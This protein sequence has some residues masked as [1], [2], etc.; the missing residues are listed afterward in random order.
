[1]TWRRLA[2]KNLLH[3]ARRYLGYMASSTCAV[4]VF[5]MFSSFT[6]NPHVKQGYMTA[7]ARYVLGGCEYIILF[8][9][10]FFILFFHAALIRMRSREFALFRVLGMTPG[11]V[12]RTVFAESIVTG[13]AAIAAG[14]ALGTV[15]L[16]L[17]LMAMGALLNLPVSIPFALPAQSVLLTVALFG[18]VFVLE[19]FITAARTALHTPKRLMLAERARQ[20]ADKASWWLVAL[21]IAS[22]AIAYDLA[23][24]HSLNIIVNFFPIIG[25][26]ALGTYLLFTQISVKVLGALRRRPLHGVSLLVVARFAHRVRDNALVL[27][28]VTLLSATVLSGM[29]AVFGLKAVVHQNSTQVDPFPVMLVRPQAGAFPLTAN[30]VSRQLAASGTPVAGQVTFSVAAVRAEEAGQAGSQPVHITVVSAS[31]FERVRQHLMDAEPETRSFL[32]DAPPAPGSGR[33]NVFVNYPLVLQKPLFSTNQIRVLDVPEMSFHLNGQYD[34][35][36][37]NEQMGRVSD[38]VLEVSD[39]DYA[40]LTDALPETAKYEITGFDVPD[41]KHALVATSALQNRLNAGQK[42]FLTARADVD[43]EVTQTLATMIF[44]GFFVSVL[45]LLACATVLYFRLQWQMAADKRQFSSL[46]RIGMQDREVHKTLT[47]ELL[48]L[49]FAP[50]AVGLVHSTV[51]MVDFSHLIAVKGNPWPVFVVV[52]GIYIALTAF[53]FAVARIRYAR[54]VLP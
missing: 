44:A 47:R 48:L 24:A 51:A 14:I 38:F 15:F 35:R 23:I 46:L 20:R 43:S 9:A 10:V 28:V 52:A 53:Y 7:R 6:L 30:D 16:K 17:F 41:W 50:V 19:G 49:F 18:A 36:I 40:K 11:Q 34:A 21:G 2:C 33:A 1:M 29:G 13:L 3:N 31:T 4:L 45:F 5:F 27:T 26:T 54:Q 42:P 25:L 22:I 8:F 32:T 12:W 39:A 37:L